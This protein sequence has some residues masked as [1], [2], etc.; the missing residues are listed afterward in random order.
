MRPECS[1]SEGAAI[2]MFSAY[3][4]TNLYGKFFPTAV[5]KWLPVLIRLL[6]S[7]PK[8]NFFGQNLANRS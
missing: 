8:L 5:I 3:D 1:T 4:T 6:E 7:G 2:Q